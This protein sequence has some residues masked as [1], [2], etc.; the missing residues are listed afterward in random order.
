[1]LKKIVSANFNI[2]INGLEKKRTRV[3]EFLGERSLKEPNQNRRQL[4]AILSFI[5][6]VD[7]RRTIGLMVQTVMTFMVDKKHV[8]YQG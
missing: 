7:E 2:N 1:M 5:M 4:S 8:E 6:T 3:D